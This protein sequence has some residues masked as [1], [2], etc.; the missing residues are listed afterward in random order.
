MNRGLQLMPHC[1]IN[2]NKNSLHFLFNPGE[3]LANNI[4]ENGLLLKHIVVGSWEWHLSSEVDFLL[5]Y[6]LPLPPFT[7]VRFTHLTD[8]SR[9]FQGTCTWTW[10]LAYCYRLYLFSVF[11]CT[12]GHSYCFTGL[13]LDLAIIL[14]L[15]SYSPLCIF[16]TYLP[17]SAY[18]PM[19]SQLCSYSLTLSHP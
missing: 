4:I 3:N 19:L 11:I 16:L 17:V 2:T 18:V 1:D 5:A 10:F 13:I 14:I 8:P 7:H 6:I 12:L 9:Y 15:S